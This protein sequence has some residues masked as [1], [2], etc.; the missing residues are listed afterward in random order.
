VDLSNQEQSSVPQLLIDF[1][2]T[3]MARNGLSA[4]GLAEIVEAAFQGTEVGEI[5]ED[6]I[7][8][9]VVVR[10]PERLREHRD[11]LAELPVTTAD[12]RVLRLDDV[13]RVRFDLGPS[14]VR[15][16][17]VQRVGMLTA[18]IEGSD[19][20]GTVEQARRAVSDAV[21]LPTGYRIS[22]G[23]QF[24]EGA[25]SARTLGVLSAFIMVAMYA[26]LFVAFRNHRHTLI[27]LVNLPLAMI[28]GVVAVALGEGVLS[29]AALVGFITL[30]G[31]A[32]RNGVLLVA[33]Y[34]DL[35]REGLEVADAVRRGSLE[36]LGPVLMTALTA[37]LALVPLVLAGGKPGNEIQSPMGE[38]LIGGLLTSTFLNVVLVPVLFV[39]WGGEALAH[40]APRETLD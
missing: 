39:R 5:V 35:M 8:S 7:Q 32:T 23:G 2:R 37:G 24:E 3:A 4:M 14:L 11:Q 26:L 30:F 6:G 38:V 27:V 16:E 20:V 40:R 10:L 33:R 29:I 21:E 9:R 13:A 31:I 28:G 17:N 25:K 12:G 19:L 36:R 15:R 34:Q 22:Y 18:N 1:D